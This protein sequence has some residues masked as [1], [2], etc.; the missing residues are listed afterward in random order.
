[1]IISHINTY[2]LSLILPLFALHPHFTSFTFKTYKELDVRLGDL[3][4][5]PST[6]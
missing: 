4:Q 6:E 3:K 2:S 5:A 1:M